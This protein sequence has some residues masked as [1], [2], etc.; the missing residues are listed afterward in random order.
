MHEVNLLLVQRLVIDRI[1][2]MSI[3]KIHPM[4][5]TYSIYH[6]SVPLF[7]LQ[8]VK[9]R[10]H[11]ALFHTFPLYRRTIIEI[12]CII[13]G[14]NQIFNIESASPVTQ[15]LI[16]CLVTYLCIFICWHRLVFTYFTSLQ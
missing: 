11:L 3:S 1:T 5:I 10:L 9:V 7:T 14:I 2:T 6:H 13:T 16:K 15:A 12:E 8:K 4:Y